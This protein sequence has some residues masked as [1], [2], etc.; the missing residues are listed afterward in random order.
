M[1]FEIQEEPPLGDWSS[2]G[3]WFTSFTGL[4]ILLGRLTDSDSS[5]SSRILLSVPRKDYVSTAIALGMSIHKFRS[6]TSILR[7]IE[8]S[9]LLE[10]PSTSKLRL[11][12][13]HGHLDVM[14]HEVLQDG[15]SIRCT[16]GGPYQ[17]RTQLTSHIRE[18]YLLPGSYP[19]GDYSISPQEYEGIEKSDEKEIWRSQSSPGVAVFGEIENFML[20]ASAHIKNDSLSRILGK[21]TV[22]LEE[23]ARLDLYSGHSRAG[24]INTY[25]GTSE[26]SK[27]L[28]E[29][30]SM[31]NLFD[32]IVLDG[33]N[34]INRLCAA[35]KL[36]DKSV[37]SILELGVPR[38]QGK[39]L[40]TYTAEL[41]RYNS[42]DITS[43]LGWK[44]PTGV[45]IWGWS[46]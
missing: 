13:K 17:P 2:V 36:I 19:E 43:L 15:Q 32:W 6:K 8:V 33:N 42:I 22:T 9:D 25:G 28:N 18:I 5:T 44:P 16:I 34:A 21:E 1:P 24:L 14:F 11:V 10:L 23:A 29:E 45:N 4:G 12:L 35:E 38:S 20:Q 27:I 3:I 40:D 39:A 26:F 7:R 41:N 30:H 31:V 46:R 37:L